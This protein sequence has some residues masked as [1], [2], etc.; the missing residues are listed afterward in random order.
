[1]DDNHLSYILKVKNLKKWFPLGRGIFSGIFGTGER[2][3]LKAVDGINFTIEPGKL[4]GLAGESGC[5]KTTTGM[6]V[7]NLYPPTSGQIL[8]KDKEVSSIKGRTGLKEFRKNAQI[9]FQ[10]YSFWLV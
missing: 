9:V 10:R 7:L 1:M 3:F 5:G 8:F 2:R 6:T 4:L